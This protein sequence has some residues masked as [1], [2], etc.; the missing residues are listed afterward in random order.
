[1]RFQVTFGPES[2]EIEA[3]SAADAWSAFCSVNTTANR[4][5][6]LYERVIEE[7]KPPEESDV[8]PLVIESDAGTVTVT[9]PPFET[10]EPTTE[11]QSVEPAVE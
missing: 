3:A 5:P 8:T 1:M 9:Q 7:I 2:R 10:A 11:P 6:N 4:H